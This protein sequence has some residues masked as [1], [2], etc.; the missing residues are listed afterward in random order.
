MREFLKP[1]WRKIIIT[2]VM[3]MLT[4]INSMM[5]ISCA[6]PCEQSLFNKILTLPHIFCYRFPSLTVFA[7]ICWLASPVIIWY[8]LSCLIIFIYDRVKGG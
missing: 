4:L 2:I 3:T 8:L 7:V 5:L 1:D 6:G